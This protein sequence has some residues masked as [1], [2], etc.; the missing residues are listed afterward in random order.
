V[1]FQEQRQQ[2]RR[3]QMSDETDCPGNCDVLKFLKIENN[4]PTQ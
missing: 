3:L 2:Q 4:K 1:W